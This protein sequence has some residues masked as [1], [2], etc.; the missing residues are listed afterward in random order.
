MLFLVFFVFCFLNIYYYEL[1]G[2]PDAALFDDNDD[3]V[4]DDADEVPITATLLSC[5][6]LLLTKFST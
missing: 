2:D 4:G 1:A 3:D 5:A 6:D